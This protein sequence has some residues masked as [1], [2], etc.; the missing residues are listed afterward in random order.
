MLAAGHQPLEACYLCSQKSLALPSSP[1]TDTDSWSWVISL[2]SFLSLPMH[3]DVEFPAE[4]HRGRASHLNNPQVVTLPLRP[5]H[6]EG[7][8]CPGRADRRN[9]FS[10]I[11]H[12][13]QEVS[14]GIKFLSFFPS[15]PHSIKVWHNVLHSQMYSRV[16]L[17]H[18]QF[19]GSSQILLLSNL[20]PIPCLLLSV[21]KLK[22]HLRISDK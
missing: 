15:V 13:S 14:H 10:K 4:P 18:Q 11:L 17:T 22:P 9:P 19:Q 7:L 6:T 20:T 5:H 3:T 1:V 2:V 8:C 12:L 21:I 16:I